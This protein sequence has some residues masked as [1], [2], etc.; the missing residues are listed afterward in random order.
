MLGLE[1]GVP[2]LADLTACGQPWSCPHGRP[3][4][5]R[6]SERDLAHAFGR[7]GVRDIARGRDEQSLPLTAVDETA[8]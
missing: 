6:L 5:L 8:L 7:R 2:L 3:T 1:N 4:V